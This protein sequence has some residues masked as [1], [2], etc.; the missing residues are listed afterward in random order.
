MSKM[1]VPTVIRQ[2]RK[3]PLTKANDIAEN[4]QVEADLYEQRTAKIDWTKPVYY[5]NF[6]PY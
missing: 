6:M 2:S 3:F 4:F 5:K 1:T